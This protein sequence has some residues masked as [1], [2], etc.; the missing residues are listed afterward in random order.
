MI[1]TSPAV[2]P[3]PLEDHA[4]R[5]AALAGTGAL[6]A[7]S[8]VGTALS[9]YLLVTH[10]LL[11]VGVAPEVR[12]LVLAAAEAPL[13]PLL[14]VGTLRRALGMASA[15]A[16]A[17]SYGLT[18]VRWL[19]QRYPRA[20]RAIRFLEGLFGRFGVAMLVIVPGY[21][22]S[23]LAGAARTR[24]SVF[25]AATLTGQ[26]LFV[27]ATLL[28]GEAVGQWTRPLLSFLTAHLAECTLACVLLV[29]LQQLFSRRRAAL[30]WL[31]PPKP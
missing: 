13:L 12:H 8:L 19:E 10:P 9:P 2:G 11:L 26:L 18:A 17:A 20:A 6:T 22:V 30:A 5:R 21:T 3:A 15:Y 31:L 4:L 25:L 16:L 28:F 14:L 7:L 27:G 1:P 23:A 24:P 29:V